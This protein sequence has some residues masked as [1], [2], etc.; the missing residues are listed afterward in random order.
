ML[1]RFINVTM[2]RYSLFILL[3]LLSS[4]LKAE[5]PPEG[6]ALPPPEYDYMDPNLE[7]PQQTEVSEIPA[8][9]TPTTP[10]VQG[11]RSVAD[12]AYRNKDYDTAIKHY[13]ALAKEGD[14]EASLIV[15]TMYEEGQGTDKD[16]A[17]ARAW[18]KKADDTK[19]DDGAG[20]Q[21]A[22]ALESGP[23]T[24][25]EIAQSEKI[26]N[27]L[28]TEKTPEQDA[29]RN[30]DAV[31]YRDYTGSSY[32]SAIKR[33][34]TKVQNSFDQSE[35]VKITPE[36]YLSDDNNQLTKIPEFKHYKPERYS[37]QNGLQ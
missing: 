23:M 26:Y 5:E 30:N 13:K 25:E 36:K 24:A 15:G 37:R 2:N 3:F 4:G 21:L 1:K 34:A 9:N 27:E 33:Q 28:Q 19:A 16:Q 17:A 12:E 14:G 32:R 20:S 31:S 35:Q 6:T 11:S 29:S 10:T 18:Y 8:T 7:S 22:E